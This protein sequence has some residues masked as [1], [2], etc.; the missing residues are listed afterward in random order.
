MQLL[1]KDDVLY[2]RLT[3]ATGSGLHNKLV[4]PKVLHPEVLKELHEGSLGGH[5]GTEKT[6][7]KLKERFYWSGHYK[8]VQ[9]W[10]S[11]CTIRKSPTP[12]PKAKLC[13][14][15]MGS[16]MELVAMDILRP[17]P[18][19]TPSNSYVLV[20][21]DYFTKWMEAY[22]IPNQD[23]IT[24]ANKLV[25]EFICCFSVPRQLHSDQGAQFELQVITEVCKLLHID[26]S[27]TTAYHPQSDGLIERFNRTLIQM[28]ATCADTH[29]STGKIILRRYVCMA[30][31]VSK[32]SSTEYRTRT[33]FLRDVYFADATNSAF[34]QFYF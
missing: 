10:C 23:A 12:R 15:T 6:L 24:V 32:Q 18:E 33:K 26:K 1:L 5:L 8:A 13:N 7:W 3:S 27:R 25:N 30:Y 11:T 21:G 28:L 14:V 34:S 29:H 20:V 4:V 17:L 22:P 31:N 16:P 19:T 2:C 9:Q